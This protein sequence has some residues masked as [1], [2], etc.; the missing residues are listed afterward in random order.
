[1]T[2]LTTSLI[3]AATLLLAAPA[4]A[5]AQT[6]QDKAF[7]LAE[8]GLGHAR[9]RRFE[10]AAAL[11]EEALKL[12]PHPEFF[13]NLA[14]ANEEMKQ[15]SAAYAY[16]SEA[17]RMDP[18]YT[19]AKEARQRMTRI[20]ASLRKTHGLVRVRSVPSQ[21][22]IAI[23][24]EGH[25][26]ERHLQTPVERWVPAGAVKLVGKKAEFQDETRE[27]AVQAGDEQTIELVLRPIER[28]GFLDVTA[29]APGAQVFLNGA[30][31][32]V[33]PMRGVP[34]PV[35]SYALEIRAPGFRAFKQAIVVEADKPTQVAAAMEP[36]SVAKVEEGG[37]SDATGPVLMT[38]GGAALVT[39]VVLHAV[40]FSKANEALPPGPEYNERQSTV[41]ALEVGAF[42]SYATAA[43]LAGVGAYLIWG[44][45][46]AGEADGFGDDAARMTPLV[47]PTRDGAV[48]GAH[49]RF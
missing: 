25:P 28:K 24:A 31:V 20:E 43:G 19:Y 30:L 13:H 47:A 6:Q 18:G 12:S 5:S 42:L 40:A 11:F 46:D 35:G 41:T 45:D 23:E 14:R 22:E 37:G 1:M 38:L 34:Y 26:A 36:D 27:Y 44:G 16:F 8:Q 2:R 9:A 49:L 3:L 21:V 39:G 29:N 7:K 10:K 48:F 4:P 33:A 17:L 15:L 32:D